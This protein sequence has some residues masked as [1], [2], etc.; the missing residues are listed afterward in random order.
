MEQ[1]QTVDIQSVQLVIEGSD[2][3]HQMRL[4]ERVDFNVH[5]QIMAEAGEFARCCMRSICNL[6]EKCDMVDALT[7]AKPAIVSSSNIVALVDPPPH[8]SFI[9]PHILES[10]GS[11]IV[12]ASLG[13]LH[14]VFLPSLA[15]DY[16]KWAS[17]QAYREERAQHAHLSDSVVA[18]S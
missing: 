6:T 4:T 11:A 2:F 12:S 14:R 10:T 17:S 18:L 8:F 1:P 5:C 3:V 16:A 7:G 9:P 15:A 13:A